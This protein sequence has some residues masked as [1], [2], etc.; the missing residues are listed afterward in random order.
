MRRGRVRQR[1]R[2]LE[3]KMSKGEDEQRKGL[4][5]SQISS[6]EKGGLLR[7]EDGKRRRGK[8]GQRGNWQ[9]GRWT[10]RKMGRAVEE[11]R[12][13]WVEGKIVKSGR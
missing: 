12:G 13:I 4:G 3:W 6:R 7:L 11:Q 10:E 2:W 8:S 5:V 9:R 1:G